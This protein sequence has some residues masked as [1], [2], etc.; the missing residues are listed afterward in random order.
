MEIVDVA[1]V[2]RRVL[3][4]A[5]ARD[6]AVEVIE[7]DP[8]AADTATFCE[9]YGY[10]LEESGN[11]IVVR[12]KSGDLRYAACLVQATRQLDLNRHA[13]Q[14][15]GARKASFA[16]A[17]ETVEVTGM[18]PGG[19]TPFGLPADVPVFVD[20]SVLS[21]ERVIVGGGGRGLKLRVAS[22][23]LASV[24]NT[25]VVPISRSRPVSPT[26]VIA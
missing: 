9:R 24:P 19:V 8:A 1:E 23:A 12:S 10:A 11:C 16:S 2:E 18:M 15:V 6:P 17:E 22:R 5:R 7:I 4:A 25:R 3:E 13:R 20:D 21:L 14:L 26:S